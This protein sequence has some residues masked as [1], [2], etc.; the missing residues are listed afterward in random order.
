MG[1]TSEGAKTERAGAGVSRRKFL[2][3]AATD[4]WARTL[5]FSVND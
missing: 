1:K 3:R 5:R 4:A 2:E